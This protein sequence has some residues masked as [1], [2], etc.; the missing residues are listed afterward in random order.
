LKRG[1][2]LILPQ[3][4]IEKT[5]KIY[6]GVS[7]AVS[8]SVGDRDLV[9]QPFMLVVKGIL[10]HSGDSSRKL[11]PGTFE[12]LLDVDIGFSVHEKWTGCILFRMVDQE[13]AILLAQLL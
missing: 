10:L 3:S 13:Q 8:G 4:C 11:R 7:R 6:S 9:Y 5:G 1:D 2:L 12:C